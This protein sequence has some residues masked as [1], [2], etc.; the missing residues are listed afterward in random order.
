MLSLLAPLVHADSAPQDCPAAAPPPRVPVADSEAVGAAL[1]SRGFV[2]LTNLT[3]EGAAADWGAV[4]LGLPERVFPGR[5]L[6][7]GSNTLHAVHEENAKVSDQYASQCRESP[8]GCEARSSNFTTAGAPLLPHTDG[9]VYGDHMPDVIFLVAEAPAERG[10]ENFV[11]DGEAVLVRLEADA[12][13]APLVGAAQTARVDLTERV[14]SGGIATGRE[15]FGPIFRRRSDG[16]V[17]WRRQLQ[18]RAYE[19]GIE[20][21]ADGAPSSVRAE[22][23]PYQSLWRP[24]GAVHEAEQTEAMLEAVDAAIQREAGAAERFS[25]RRG[26]ALLINNYRVLHGREGYTSRGRDG[27]KV[28]RVWCWTDRSLGLPEGM[29]EV[30]SPFDADALLD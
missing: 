7:S 12:A 2:V 19:S 11:V 10:G 23:Q 16:G 5:L 27:R 22:L 17:W 20:Q 3:E 25:L 21:P 26:E 4:A 6:S 24:A 18:T 29:A 14:S 15:A 13:T 9:Y 8:E 30:G 28:W 1:S